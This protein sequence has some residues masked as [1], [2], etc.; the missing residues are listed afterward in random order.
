MA[1][2]DTRPNGRGAG[3]SIFVNDSIN[4]YILPDISYNSNS[5]GIGSITVQY[6]NS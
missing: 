6:N 2:W 4:S 3:M 5:I 1:I